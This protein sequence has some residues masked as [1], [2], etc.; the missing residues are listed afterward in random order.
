M[1]LVI[2]TNFY[3]LFD[4]GNEIAI[5]IMTE[6]QKY[7]LPSIVVG[8]LCH[9]YRHGKRYEENIKRL[10]LFIKTFHVE[11]VPID[12]D[13]ALLFGDIASS[14]KRKGRP[15]PTN[16]IWIAA[17]TSFIGGTLATTDGDFLHVDQIRVKHIKN[18]ISH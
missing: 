17:C 11:I 16:D 6:A 2:D 8:E 14:L 5:D 4:V 9:G 12:F 3:S 15:I 10:K 7:Y 13:I 1:K 18:E